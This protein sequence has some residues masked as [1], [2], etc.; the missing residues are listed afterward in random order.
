MK[1]ASIK[2]IQE[3]AGRKTSAMSARYAHLATEHKLSAVELISN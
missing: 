1:R 2:D 3:L